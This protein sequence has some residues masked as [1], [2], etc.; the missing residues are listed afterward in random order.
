MNRTIIA[1]DPGASGGI[2]YQLSGSPGVV[3]EKMPETEGDI[4]NTLCSV[5]EGT[6]GG[7]ENVTVFVEKVGGYVKGVRAPGSAM[8]NFGRN[9][10][11]ILGCVQTSGARVELVPPQ[12]WQKPLGI[13]TKGTLKTGDWKNKLKSHAQ[14]LFPDKKVTLN[15]A[16]ALL[17]LEYG[18]RRAA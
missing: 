11:F 5:I 13:G 8:F 12:E 16:D 15:T 18:K 17:I 4:V 3:A 6:Q 7:P 10:G 14:R 1:I 9:F 2:A